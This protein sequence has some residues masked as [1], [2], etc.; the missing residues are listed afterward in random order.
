MRRGSGYYAAGSHKIG[1]DGD[2]VT[3]P[4][5]SPMFARCLAMQVR[6]V[7]DRTG[8]DVLELGPG[9]GILAADLFAELKAQGAAPSRYRLLEVSPELRER[10]RARIAERHPGDVDRFEWIERLPERIDGM[11]LANEVLDVVPCA[12]VHRTGGGDPREGRGGHRGRL[13]MGGHGPSRRR[14]QAPRATRSSRRATTTT[15][16]K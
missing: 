6:Q 15:S 16:R 2:F 7:L 1:A 9:T 10:Q 4:E 12:L 14:A 8:G 3:A 5:I 13:R 11:V